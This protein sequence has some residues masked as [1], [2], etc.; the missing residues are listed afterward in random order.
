[1]YVTKNGKKTYGASLTKYVWP[2]LH[3]V[4]H[5]RSLFMLK[6]VGK[7]KRLLLSNQQNLYQQYL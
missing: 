1:M 2:N 4:A 3:I 6:E 5:Q 7:E